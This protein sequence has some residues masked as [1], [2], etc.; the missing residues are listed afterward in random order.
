[1]S[2][3]RMER[4]D[5]VPAVQVKTSNRLW[6]CNNH[7]A[8]PG[9]MGNSRVTYWPRK[10]DMP[11]EY[12]DNSYVSCRDSP[13]ANPEKQR[14]PL[15]QS[16]RA[17]SNFAAGISMSLQVM[18]MG[19][20]IGIQIFNWLEEALGVLA[21]VPH[22]Y[23]PEGKVLPNPSPHRTME[24]N[25][26]GSTH[27]STAV[28]RPTQGGGT[29]VGWRITGMLKKARRDKAPPNSPGGGWLSADVDAVVNELCAAG[30]QSQMLCR[31]C[32]D[33]IVFRPPVGWISMDT[34]NHDSLDEMVKLAYK[35][36][37][38]RAVIVLTVP[39]NNNMG[40]ADVGGN[41]TAMNDR[42]RFYA[43]K[44]RPDGANSVQMV[45][46]GDFATLTHDIA[47]YNAAA[48]GY[49][50]AEALQIQVQGPKMLR[51]FAA[52]VC[53]ERPSLQKGNTCKG[54]WISSDGM[55]WC[56]QSVAGRLA[57][58]I[59]C[60]LKCTTAHKAGRDGTELRSNMLT[61]IDSTVPLDA[62]NSPTKSHHICQDRCNTEFFSFSSKSCFN[63]QLLTA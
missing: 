1:M 52:T 39:L 2:N 24:R 47:L 56:P 30:N 36:F 26:A 3:T 37:R 23:S 33:A 29:L 15:P 57:M 58:G 12:K 9:R 44:Y 34:V 32:L 16:I 14:V 48:M 18:I 20:S 6:A 8:G 43:R 21:P 49:S 35:L 27:I 46:Y 22:M 17:L 50:D 19:D 13:H 61:Y 41:W 63:K 40:P 4:S 10:M 7:Q 54:S 5:E 38:A 25:C 11:A 62:S 45:L 31:C 59:A 60:L 53:G 55:H 42:I 51:S 28:T